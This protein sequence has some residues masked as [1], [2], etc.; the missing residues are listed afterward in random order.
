MGLNMVVVSF[1]EWIWTVT[2]ASSQRELCSTR[3]TELGNEHTG[4]Q[5]CC[6]Q[7]PSC[8]HHFV[9]EQVEAQRIKVILHD[10]AGK[11]GSKA[12]QGFTCPG[13]SWSCTHLLMCFSASILGCS[14]KSCYL[15]SLCH[16]FLCCKL[17]IEKQCSLQYE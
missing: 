15:T 7:N 1:L 5:E 16:V 6:G 4:H 8:C 9:D 17:E 3:G 10:S 12:K 14:S 13:G 2:T 11:K